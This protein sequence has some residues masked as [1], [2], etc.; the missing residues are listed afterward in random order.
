M[1]LEVC[2]KHAPIEEISFS[3]KKRNN[4]WITKSLK[5]SIRKKHA[6]YSKTMIKSGYD[7]VS[8]DKY[9]KYRNTLTSV[10]RTA[11]K[12]YYGSLVE[13]RDTN[14]SKKTWKHINE[15]LNKKYSSQNSTR[16]KELLRN[17]GSNV[18]VTS[19]IDIANTFK[20]FFC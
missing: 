11:K 9:N 16:V 4:P 6:L 13:T 19:T 3:S 15:L 5:R 20:D 1:F 18:K 12:I 8:V 2:N 14:N 10:I 7:K 17:D